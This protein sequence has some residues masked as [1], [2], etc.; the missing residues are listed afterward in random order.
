MNSKVPAGL[1][2]SVRNEAIPI[3][4]EMVK[5]GWVFGVIHWDKEFENKLAFQ[6]QISGRSFRL[7]RMRRTRSAR[8][9]EASQTRIFLITRS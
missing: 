6:R 8:K 1:T 7:R 5:A 9:A 2:E 4:D 3:R